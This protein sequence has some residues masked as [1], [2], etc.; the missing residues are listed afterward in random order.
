MPNNR[1][2]NGVSKRKTYEVIK[3]TRNESFQVE[4]GGKVLPFGRLGN[5]RT[6]DP[7][8]AREI[9]KRWGS[10]TKGATKEVVVAEVEHKFDFEPG[11]K[12]THSFPGMPWHR[13]DEFG[14]VIKG[15]SNGS[16]NARQ[17]AEAASTGDARQAQRQPSTSA[18]TCA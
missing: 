6:S 7:G 16:R 11:H 18:C 17:E 4:V 9:E 13:H 1:Y 5:F 8:V 14:K 10:Y 15:D 3:A 2:Q 12:Y